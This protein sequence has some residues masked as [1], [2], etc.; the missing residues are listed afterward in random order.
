[1]KIREILELRGRLWAIINKE[2]REGEIIYNYDSI[3]GL[4]YP[5]AFGNENG[6]WKTVNGK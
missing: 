5:A 6:I 1:M 3:V 4:N 2:V